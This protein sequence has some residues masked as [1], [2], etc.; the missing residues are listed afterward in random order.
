MK[1]DTLNLAVGSTVQLQHEGPGDS[2]RY[3]VKVVGYVTNGSLVVRIPSVNGNVQ[4]VR[5]GQRYTVRMLSGENV[6]AFVAK[7]LQTSM[8]PYP[9]MHLEYPRELEQIVVRNAVR[10]DTKEACK[11]R[12]TRQEDIP[13]NYRD[14]DI[15]DLSESGSKVASRIPLGEVGD[16]LQINFRLEILGELEELSVF[17]ELKNLVEKIEQNKKGRGLLHVAGV[18]FN[19]PSRFQQI[20]IHAWVMERVVNR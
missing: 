13:I 20:C 17:G 18:Q 15:V 12:N 19:E 11:V 8:R 3:V 10:V 7:V 9:H 14:A 5:E 2:Q 16:I 6:V 4:I 1:E